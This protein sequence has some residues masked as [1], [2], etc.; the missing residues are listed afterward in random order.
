MAMLATLLF[1]R[2]VHVGFAGVMRTW[3]PFAMLCAL[4]V[5]L[6]TTLP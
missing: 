5:V 4:A 6:G 2:G 3:L 1:F